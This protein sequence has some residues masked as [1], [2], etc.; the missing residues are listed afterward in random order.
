M[1]VRILLNGGGLCV[2]LTPTGF[3]PRCL[4]PWAFDCCDLLYVMY[5]PDRPILVKEM[6]Q[7]FVHELL[8]RKITQLFLQKSGISEEEPFEEILLNAAGRNFL[9]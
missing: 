3:L 2:I 1:K 8:L 4:T 7:P 9:Q 5:I 6:Q